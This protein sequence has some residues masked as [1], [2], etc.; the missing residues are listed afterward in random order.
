MA[1]TH[2]VRACGGYVF[3]KRACSSGA[4]G[5]TRD[6]LEKQGQERSIE[7]WNCDAATGS[8]GGRLHG[9]VDVDW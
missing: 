1:K 4:A 7:L 5:G 9:A 3:G 6:R 2:D 8:S